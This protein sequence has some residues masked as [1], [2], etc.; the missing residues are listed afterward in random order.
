MSCPVAHDAQRIPNHSAHSALHYDYTT[1][2]SL[3]LACEYGAFQLVYLRL[4]R[5]STRDCLF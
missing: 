4:V 5:R 3:L 2:I 1:Y